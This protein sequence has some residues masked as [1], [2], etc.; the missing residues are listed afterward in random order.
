M[1]GVNGAIPAVRWAPLL[2]T[3]PPHRPTIPARNRI[4]RHVR[5]V[6]GVQASA[7]APL[8]PL[9]RQAVASLPRAQDEG[10]DHGNPAVVAAWSLPHGTSVTVRNLDETVRRVRV[11]TE[12]VDF[13]LRVDTVMRRVFS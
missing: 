8:T 12:C 10:P 4:R 6:E 3:R 5:R 9:A 7:A 13:L 2:D 1:H 11:V